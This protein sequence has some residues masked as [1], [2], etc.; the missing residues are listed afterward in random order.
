MSN[1]HIVTGEDI[2]KQCP[3][4]EEGDRVY[5]TKTCQYFVTKASG[6]LYYVNTGD[7]KY[8]VGI[9]GK[10]VS[11]SPRFQLETIADEDLYL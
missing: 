6:L 8:L 5:D 3:D 11:L 1:Q 9:N 4:L 2:L 10:F 7:D